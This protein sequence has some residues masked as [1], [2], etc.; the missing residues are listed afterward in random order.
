MFFMAFMLFAVV[1]DAATQ[2]P[3]LVSIFSNI[4]GDSIATIIIGIVATVF[5]SAWAFLKN[6]LALVAKLARESVDVITEI[7]KSL[8]DDKLTKQE[9]ERIKSERKDVRTA[10]QELIKKKEQK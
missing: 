8:S 5:G 9:I 10:W 1:A 7:D 2:S 6:R 4:D 3:V